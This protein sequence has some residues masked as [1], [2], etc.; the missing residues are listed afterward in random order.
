[1]TIEEMDLS[2][3]EIISQDATPE[4]FICPTSMEQCY[5]TLNHQI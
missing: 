5:P 1:M 3:E 2:R 4:F